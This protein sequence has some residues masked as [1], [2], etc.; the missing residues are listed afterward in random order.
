MEGE[1]R[2]FS[3]KTLLLGKDKASIPSRWRRT[4]SS[5][6]IPMQRNPPGPQHEVP[7]SLLTHKGGFLYTPTHLKQVLITESLVYTAVIGK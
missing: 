5:R 2:P 7:T 4:I 6:A 1:L 3:L